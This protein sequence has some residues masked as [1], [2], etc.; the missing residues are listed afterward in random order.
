[1]LPCV[2]SLCCSAH[3]IVV[4]ADCLHL[5]HKNEIKSSSSLAYALIVVC[6]WYM[7]HSLVQ[8]IIGCISAGTWMVEVITGK[9]LHSTGKDPK[10]LPAVK[11]YLRDRDFDCWE[12]PGKVVFKIFPSGGDQDY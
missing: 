9:G 6:N 7:L 12:T 4:Q 2:R 8:L 1:M 3:S 10:L 11:A 5:K